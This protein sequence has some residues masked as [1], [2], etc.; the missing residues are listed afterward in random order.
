M[1]KWW[2]LPLHGQTALFVKRLFL[3]EERVLLTSVA[4][5]IESARAARSVSA[6]EADT[7]D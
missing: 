4:Y 6:T 2:H 7:A 3:F 5:R 1:A